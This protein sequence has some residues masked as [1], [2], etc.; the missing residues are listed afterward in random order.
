MK[1][2][3]GC[4][5]FIS[6]QVSVNYYLTHIYIY[7]S[8]SFFFTLYFIGSWNLHSFHFQYK[9]NC[10]KQ[11]VCDRWP[12]LFESFMIKELWYSWQFL[13]IAKKIRLKEITV[14]SQQSMHLNAQDYF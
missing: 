13:D 7:F 4:E 8:S 6:R 1:K 5:K 12:Q 10:W 9:L 3:I 2:H 11:K 14:E